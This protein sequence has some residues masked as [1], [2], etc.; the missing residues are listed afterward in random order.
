MVCIATSSAA[1]CTRGS[2]MWHGV[3]WGQ[4]IELNRKQIPIT[5]KQAFMHY[6]TITWNTDDIRSSDY[7]YNYGCRPGYGG[8]VTINLVLCTLAFTDWGRGSIKCILVWDQCQ[9]SWK[10]Y[11][12]TQECTLYV[13]QHHQA[14]DML[15]NFK[16][17]FC[18]FDYDRLSGDIVQRDMSLVW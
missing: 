2:K 1:R 7:L 18:I 11:T 4:P 9:S 14:S 16:L 15:P 5:D 10:T 17:I 6:S 8:F 3:G 12:D 13:R